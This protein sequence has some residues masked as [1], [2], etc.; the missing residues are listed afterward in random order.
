MVQ[1]ESASG[2]TNRELSLDGLEQYARYDEDD[3]TNGELE[4]VNQETNEPDFSINPTSDADF[5]FKIDL[6]AGD[7]P[8]RGYGHSRFVGRGSASSDEELATELNSSPDLSGRAAPG[9]L[10]GIIGRKEA[11]KTRIIF[12]ESG[13]E[14]LKRKRKRNSGA[15]S[16]T[17]EKGPEPIKDNT[18][19][20]PRK[21]LHFS[22]QGSQ[23]LQKQPELVLLGGGRSEPPTAKLGA[24]DLN[25][26]IANSSKLG[27]ELGN[28]ST[29]YFA[30]RRRHT[31]GGAIPAPLPVP[32]SVLPSPERPGLPDVSSISGL[33]PMST[34]TP[35]H[36]QD[37]HQ[38]SASS[39]SSAAPYA[40]PPASRPSTSYPL[41]E[42]AHSQRPFDLSHVTNEDISLAL[43]AA[44]GSLASMHEFSIET[45]RSVWEEVGSLEEADKV[46]MAMRNAAEEAKQRALIAVRG[47]QNSRATSISREGTSSRDGAARRSS[48]KSGER[49]KS[50]LSTTFFPPIRAENEDEDAPPESIQEME[51]SRD[52]QLPIPPESNG[53]EMDQSSEVRRM[54]TF[55]P[56]PNR[57]RPSDGVSIKKQPVWT[58]EEDAIIREADPTK[59]KE[60]AKVKG[61]RGVRRRMTE[62][63]TS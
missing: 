15:E 1:K 20:R 6:G 45:V 2:V 31:F 30:H 50:N 58:E 14:S 7:T 22:R 40:W 10:R 60:L 34:S 11:G 17:V 5:D 9:S 25:N 27:L 32:A 24:M 43:S 23:S 61:G 57:K 4:E 62:L 37:H 28:S 51:S 41:S 21:H 56:S 3:D 8:S 33:L 13:R 26:D 36:G 54:I 55:H 39:S 46:L 53:E 44:L 48:L 63:V 35:T 59:L 47:G 12:P 19:K 52:S 38:A 29:S 42:G 49:R 18:V 16:T